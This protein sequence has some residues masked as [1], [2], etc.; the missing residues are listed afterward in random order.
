MSN[1]AAER[2]IRPLALGRKSY[3]FSGSDA[4]GERAAVIYTIVETCKVGGINPHACLADIINR[5]ADH[6]ANRIDELL[7]WNWSTQS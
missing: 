4:G 1:N 2:A 5:I 7:P 6:P 3:L